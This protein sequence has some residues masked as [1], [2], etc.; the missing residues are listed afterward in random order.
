MWLRPAKCPFMH[1][2]Q[3][4]LV[5]TLSQAAAVATRGVESRCRTALS[6]TSGQPDWRTRMQ[7][8]NP[9]SIREPSA[10]YS[11]GVVAGDMMFLSGQCGVDENG[12]SVG[13]IAAQTRRSVE[14]MDLVLQEAG[15][16]LTDVVY[17]TTF[18]TDLANFDAYDAA[19][20][21]AFGDHR[22]ARATVAARIHSPDLLVEIQ[23][24]A[25]KG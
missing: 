20:A 24:I 8:V 12:A 13:D 16:A 18:L 1:A 3:Y 19:Y 17:V 25:K 22:P 9:A 2:F 7:F 15:F 4:T 5:K 14:N 11:F 10:A 23:A 6:R 21:E